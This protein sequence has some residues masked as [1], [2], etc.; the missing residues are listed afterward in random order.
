MIFSE[1]HRASVI[2][3]QLR[4]NLGKKSLAVRSIR[5]PEASDGISL[6]LSFYSLNVQG[7]TGLLLTGLQKLLRLFS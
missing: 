5:K 7:K 4:K 6:I 3:G 2:S 1:E